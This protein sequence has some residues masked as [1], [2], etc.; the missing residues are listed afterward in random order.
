MFFVLLCLIIAALLMTGNSPDPSGWMM[1]LGLGWLAGFL[2]CRMFAKSDQDKSRV[3]PPDVDEP[4]NDQA[5]F[6]S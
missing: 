1:L 5:I 4:S 3:L 6:K 2:D